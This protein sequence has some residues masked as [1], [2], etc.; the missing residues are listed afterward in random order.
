MPDLLRNE[1]RQSAVTCHRH[2][3]GKIEPLDA[4]RSA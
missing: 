3:R 4:G 2:S 1:V